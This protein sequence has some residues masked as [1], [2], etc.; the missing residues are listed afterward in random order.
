MVSVSR[1]VRPS[2]VFNCKSNFPRPNLIYMYSLIKRW[3]SDSF[4]G[5]EYGHKLQILRED[6]NSSLYTFV[7]ETAAW[8]P[9]RPS[10]LIL[11]SYYRFA[12]L[13]R[14]LW[15]SPLGYWTDASMSFSAIIAMIGKHSGFGP[16][17]SVILSPA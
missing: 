12:H 10:E 9:T 15:F 1:S 2:S 13:S 14:V 16:A 8:N 7:Q 11:I 17:G 5:A 6:Y 4:D 3:L